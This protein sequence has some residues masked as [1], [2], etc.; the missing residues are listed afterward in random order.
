MQKIELE[1]ALSVLG[2]NKRAIIIQMVKDLARIPGIQAIALGGSYARG[3]ACQDSDVD[4]GLY[5]SENSPFSI[6]SI[7]AL[8]K[9]Y[10]S[11]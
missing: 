5:Y 8:A 6:N 9:K 10:C 4:L 3:T 11:I 7:K 2:E 1:E